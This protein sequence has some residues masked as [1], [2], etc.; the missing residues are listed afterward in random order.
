[1]FSLLTR[2]CVAVA[3][4]WAAGPGAPVPQLDSELPLPRARAALS[5][6]DEALAE[7][8]ESEHVQSLGSLSFGRPNN[9]QLLGGV[10]LQDNQF[11]EVVAPDFAWGTRE[12]VGYLRKAVE[13]VHE[14]HP[15]TP[16]LHVGHL[17]KPEGGYLS[18]HKSHQSGRDVDLGF[19]YKDKRQ[20]YRRGTA[21]TLDIPRTW[22]LVRALITETD[23]DMIIVDASIQRLLRAHARKIGED[24][25]W[26]KQVFKGDAERPR[27]FRHIWGHTTH[28]HVR[29][30]NPA[31]QTLAQRAYPHLLEADV[32]EPVT[33]Y[34]R[35]RAR[36]GD[37]LGRLARRYG[38]SVRAIQSA[39]GLGSTTIQARKVYKIPRRGGPPPGKKEHLEIPPRRLPPGPPSGQD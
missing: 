18:P 5:L 37:T 8:I 24:R 2:T 31:A 7:R 33:V 30:F 17:S 12:T 13:K 19:Y 1:M 15:N 10:R 14:K 21:Q 28:L 22:S 4:S 9:G 25:E 38:T 35:Y 6:S 23:V 34:T 27:I 29:F 39:N 36:Q 11:F 32:L 16:P 26:L 3:L 20:W